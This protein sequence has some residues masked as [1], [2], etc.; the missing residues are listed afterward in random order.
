MKSKASAALAA[1]RSRALAAGALASALALSSTPGHALSFQFSFTNVTGTASGT[2][3]GLVEGLTDNALSG[4]TDV[5][6]QSYPAALVGLH[7]APFI[8]DVPSFSPSN[9]FQVVN[10]SITHGFFEAHVGIG[11]FCLSLLTPGWPGG[12]SSSL[13]DLIAVQIVTGP[14]SFTPVGVAVPGPIAGAGLPGLIFASAGLLGWWR[15]KRKAETA[16]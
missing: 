7:P 1:F 11:D 13:N 10:G 4:A 8:V 15:R 2:V 9:N 14:V 16:A 3:T 12:A 6:L 5:I